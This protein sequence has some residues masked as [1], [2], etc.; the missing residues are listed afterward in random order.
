M[1]CILKFISL[2]VS[3]IFLKNEVGIINNRMVQKHRGVT[4]SKSRRPTVFG[5]SF[6]FKFH[7]KFKDTK[8]LHHNLFSQLSE[9]S[10]YV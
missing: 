4:F 6:I 7:V 5:F 10:E 1:R 3:F 9:N 8:V 2:P